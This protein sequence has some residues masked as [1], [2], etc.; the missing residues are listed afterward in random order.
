VMYAGVTRKLLS[1][2]GKAQGMEVSLDTDSLP[3]G[4]VVLG[5]QKAKKLRLDNS[6]D[7]P[8]SYE[9]VESSF[10][11][12]F[13]ISPLSGKLAPGTEASFDVVFRPQ[14]VDSDVRQEGI[15]LMIV[16]MSPLTLTCSGAAINQPAE[17]V[18]A[19]RFES[20]ARK[21]QE[22]S[23]KVSNPTEKDWFVTPAFE[24]IH[25]RGPH[26]LKIPANGSSNLNITYFPLT[27]CAKLDKAATQ[28]LAD[29][30]S[31]QG[32]LFLALP[33]GSALLYKLIGTAGPPE[34]S[35]TVNIETAAKKPA[36][37]LLRLSN[38]LAE[39]QI[40]R[41]SVNITEKPSQATFIVAANA[42]EVGANGTKDF[43]A[44]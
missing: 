2:S 43:H 31:H 9:W 1:V 37:I 44:R 35:G 36:N 42:V 14:F 39:P 6:G 24:G 38:W 19:V 40:F 28:T 41:V 8:L 5:S 22:K 17:S 34:C 12:H 15:M 20:L 26:E 7:M 27:M 10:G 32:K 30:S 16:G 33:D 21:A 18:Q 13:K 3:F 11:S 23:V 29:E 25:W 4:T